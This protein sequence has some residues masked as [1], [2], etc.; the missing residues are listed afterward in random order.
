MNTGMVDNWNG[1]MFDIGPI[2]PFVGWEVPLVILGFIFW[3]GW[4]YLQMHMENQ[5]LEEEA[6]R[7]AQQSSDLQTILQTER[8]D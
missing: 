3:I 2:Y 4:H 1:N 7:L 5:Q 8:L 6:R